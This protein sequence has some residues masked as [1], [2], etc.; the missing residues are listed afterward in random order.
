MKAV[1]VT[2]GLSDA[3][4]SGKLAGLMSSCLVDR[5]ILVRKHPLKG[6]KI[7]NVNPPVWIARSRILFEMWRFF[8]VLF[9]GYR[10]RVELFV[11][12]QAQMHGSVAVLVAALLGA[13]SALWL[14]GSDLLIHSRHS[15]FAPI[16]R[17]SIR[18]SDTVFV[19]GDYSR[20][21]VKEVCGRICR[22]FVL[23]V[24]CKQGPMHRVDLPDKKWDLLFAGNL[25]D[26]K[27][28]LAAISIFSRV[29]DVIPTA[30]FC[31]IGEGYL[32]DEIVKH[33]KCRGLQACVDVLGQ[34]SE[35]L[36]YI[37]ASRLLII[38]S[39]SEGLPSV[40]IEASKL[41]VPVVA[42][43]VGEITNLSQESSGIIGAASGNTD[44]FV[45]P[46]LRLLLNENVYHRAS[47][48]ILEFGISHCR[49]WS[50]ENQKVVWEKA[51]I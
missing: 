20:Q 15:V 39:K 45:E 16:I 18:R 31:M 30:R 4:L 3:K 6:G 41:G 28:P 33:I 21:L 19:M 5:I 46:S 36:N 14:I 25:V 38:P 50:I 23:Q 13:K 49:K 7:V 43:L 27:D 44:S 42:S 22:V 32:M 37:G 10:H 24:V 8:L 35:P 47:D 1:L 26:V 11:G 34:V 40:L 17:Y 12:I 2:C 51:I 48:S 29:H 9:Y